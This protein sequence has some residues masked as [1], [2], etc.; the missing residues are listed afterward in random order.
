MTDEQLATCACEKL[1]VRVT[2]EPRVVAACNCLECQK[3]T[4][5]LFGVVAFFDDERI[6]GITGNSRCY[7][8]SSESGRPVR[9]YF[10]PSCG[11][12]VYWKVEFRQGSTGVA[13]GCFAD[14]NFPK[15][16]AVAWTATQHDWVEFPSDCRSSTSQKF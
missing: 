1:R 14:P 13:V 12:S 9:I 2:G 5:S 8:R 11:S 7:K 15:P 10:C 3:R 6:V 16:Q 4:G